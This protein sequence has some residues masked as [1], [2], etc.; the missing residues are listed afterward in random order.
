MHSTLMLSFVVVSIASKC[1]SPKYSATSFSTTDGFFHFHT[2]FIAEFTLQ[3][4]NNIKDSPFFAVINGNIH[5]VAVSVE[6]AK[7]QVSW[8]QEHE[9]SDAQL[10][11]IKIFDEEGIS[12][13]KKNSNTS[14]LFIIEHYHPGLT[15][16]PFISSETVALFVFIA[17]LYYAIKQKLPLHDTQCEPLKI[18]A[19]R[20]CNPIHIT[21]CRFNSGQGKFR[22]SF[23]V[24][25]TEEEKRKKK[26]KIDVMKE[27]KEPKNLFGKI[28]Y[29]LRR[30]WYIAVPAHMI[31]SILW[32]GGVYA[33]AKCGVNIVAFLRFVHAPM[34]IIEKIEE[35]PPSAGVFVIALLLYKLATPFRY[36]TTLILIQTAFWTLRRLGKLHTAREVEF[37]MRTHFEKNKIRYGRKFYR[38]RRLGVR[39]VLKKNTTGNDDLSPLQY[40]FQ[41][42]LLFFFC[43][44]LVFLDSFFA[45]KEVRTKNTLCCS[46]Q[47]LKWL[48]L[49]RHWKKALVN[50]NKYIPESY[51]KTVVS[52]SIICKYFY[53]MSMC[54]GISIII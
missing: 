41:C 32:F 3:C 22:W 21:S 10:L 11:A 43:V 50:A 27:E 17:A 13:Y 52:W 37:K 33:V 38:Y 4:S 6:S 40:C 51:V 1:E 5:S 23:R 34:I 54:C 36:M 18:V 29:Y 19:T 48:A 44:Y 26:E 47:L 30:Y 45:T 12:A 2:T 25:M 9:Q 46:Q 49:I 15:R 35:V 39:N 14:P 28:K 31:G 7:Y 16:K 42:M 24:S 20:Q 53:L 8:S